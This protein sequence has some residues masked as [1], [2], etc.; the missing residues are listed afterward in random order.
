MEE[1]VFWFLLIFA[2]ALLLAALRLFLA[3]DPRKSIL[4]SRSPEL[5]KESL[6]KA[7]EQARQIAALVAAVGTAIAVYCILALIRLKTAL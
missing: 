4:L 1:Y 6:E 5:R 7:K 3:K 2:A